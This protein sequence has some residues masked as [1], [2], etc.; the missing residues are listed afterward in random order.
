MRGKI[1]WTAGLL[2]VAGITVGA[3]GLTRI[4]ASTPDQARSDCPGKVVCP[5]SGAEVCKDQCPLRDV[6][7][8]DCPGKIECPVTGEL[9]CRDE[10][11]LGT[12]SGA[13]ATAE[14][15]RPACCRGAKLGE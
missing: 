1:F 15:D 6:S 3:Y 4:Q 9:V 7:R 8:T 12:D 11:P 14:A 13:E 10:C 5:L 2:L